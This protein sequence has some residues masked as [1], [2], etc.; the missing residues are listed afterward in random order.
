M[1]KYIRQLHVLTWQTSF[2]TWRILWQTSY[3]G[4]KFRTLSFDLRQ[5]SIL[6]FKSVTSFFNVSNTYILCWIVLCL[7]FLATH[8]KQCCVE[9]SAS[10]IPSYISHWDINQNWTDTVI[11]IMCVCC[12][13]LL[14]HTYIFMDPTKHSTPRTQ[15]ACVNTDVFYESYF[16]KN[17]RK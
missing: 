17:I 11:L 1:S 7:T 4:V 10:L 9:H 14:G 12:K 3:R 16:I 8:I 13:Q 15:V 6:C 2:T 5:I